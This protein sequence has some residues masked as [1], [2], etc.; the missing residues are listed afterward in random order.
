MPLG[1]TQVFPLSSF[2]PWIS[3]ARK[4]RYIQV[5]A[6]WNLVMLPSTAA[7]ARYQPFWR[8]PPFLLPPLAATAD[9]Y[10]RCRRQSLLRCCLLPP[11]LTAATAGRSRCLPPL[12]PADFV[13]AAAVGCYR[14][15]IWPLTEQINTFNIWEGKKTNHYIYFT[16]TPFNHLPF[17]HCTIIQ[18]E[19]NHNKITESS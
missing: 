1:T 15:R 7:T 3:L 18:F 17:Y 5:S 12:F 16:I 19:I 2:F 8:P 14:C 6:S 4:I 10:G 11:L 9:V 13:D